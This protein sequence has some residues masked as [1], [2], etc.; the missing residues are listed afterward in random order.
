MHDYK[1]HTHTV[2]VPLSESEV[3]HYR[4]NLKE[5][6]EYMT[7][8]RGSAHLDTNQHCINSCTAEW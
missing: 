4:G 3:E 7:G 8:S 2:F 6:A 1:V 5:F